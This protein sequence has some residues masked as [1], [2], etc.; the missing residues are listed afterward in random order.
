PA[1]K[2]LIWCDWNNDK[3]FDPTTEL[4][5]TLDSITSGPNPYKGVIKIPANAFLGKIKMRI[6]MVDGANNPNYDPCG[7][8]GYGEVED[9]TLN[10]TDNI[11]S[12][13]PTGS[14]NQNQP[15]IN[16]YP[17]PNNGA[18]TLDIS[19]PDN[20]LYNVEIANVLGQ[21]IYTESLNINNRNYNFS[22][23]FDRTTLSKGIYIVK[24]SGNGANTNKKIIIE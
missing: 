11:T 13:D 4:A 7:T 24:L 10:C 23:I 21:I 20:G 5:A 2:V 17:N 16:V 22:K 6:K 19:F 3:V 1:D 15:F 12:I 9:Y 18:F 14:D 8:T